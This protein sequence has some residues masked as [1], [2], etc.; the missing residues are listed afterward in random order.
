QAPQEHAAGIEHI[1]E[2]TAGTGNVIVF[3]M[4]L[5]RVGHKNFAVEIPDTKRCISSRKIG[6]D[7][8][9]WSYLMKILIVGFHL[10]GVKIRYV[11]KIVTAS[12]AERCPFVNGTVNAAVCAVINC[13]DGIR[14]VHAR[15]PT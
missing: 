14:R 7:E 10:A 11:E 5:L 13:D 15:V 2:A 12:D 1:D 9:V 6:I 3:L 8:A 4:I